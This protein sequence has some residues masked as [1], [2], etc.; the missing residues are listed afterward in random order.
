MPSKSTAPLEHAPLRQ[1]LGHSE[2][3]HKSD[4][5]TGT[6]S[7][8]SVQSSL[9]GG[10]GGGKSG[11]CVQVDGKKNKG[12]N[13]GGQLGLDAEAHSSPPLAWLSRVGRYL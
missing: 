3:H 12:P 7:C 13:E 5:Q 8:P 2:V 10:G 11:Q 9:G 1:L 6:S 4:R